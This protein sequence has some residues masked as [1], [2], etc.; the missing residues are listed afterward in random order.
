MPSPIA[1]QVRRIVTQIVARFDSDPAVVQPAQINKDVWLA[2][3]DKEMASAEPAAHA[4]A[5]HGAREVW[6]A[7]LI[8]SYIRKSK[9]PAIESLRDLN[10]IAA[11]VRKANRMVQIKIAAHGRVQYLA[12][13][14]IDCSVRELEV[15]GQQY[16]QSGA[17]DIRRSNYYLNIARQLRLRGLSDDDTL[18]SFLAGQTAAQASQAQAAQVAI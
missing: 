5:G 7:S 4:A 18:A 12:K 11:R 13:R 3:V 10:K 8:E 2:K 6:Y 9:D 15:L 1:S 17:A 16:A 14:E